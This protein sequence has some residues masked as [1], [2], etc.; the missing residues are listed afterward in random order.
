MDRREFVQRATA[1]TAA[2]GLAPYARPGRKEA[3]S[4]RVVVDGLDTSL[5]NEGFLE[6]LETGGVDC[7][8]KSMGEPAYYGMIYA[9][10]AHHRDV[11]VPAFTVKEIREAKS[12]GKRSIIFGAQHANLLEAMMPKDVSGT[13]G[14]LV[15]GLKLY[16][17]L[18]QR[19]QGICYNVA[20]VFGGGCLDPRVPLTRAGHRLV[21]E[22]HKIRM[23]LDVAGHT[24]EQTSLDAL[25]MSTGVPVICTHTNSAA[26]NPNARATTDRV[27]EAIAWTGG[28]VGITS[29]SDFQMRNPANYQ[30]Q[31]KTSPQATLDVHLKQ[32]DYMKKRIGIDHI[33]LGPDFVWGWGE[34]LNH[35]AENSLTFPPDALSDGPAVTTKDYENISK[36]PNLIAGLR[37][38]GWSEPDLD[39]LLGANWLRVYEKVWG[40]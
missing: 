40:A 9:F 13:Y 11:I 25:E 19:F 2:L 4:S 7:V 16:Y 18:G 23:I 27:L 14:Q 39:K 22:V 12:Q 24:G 17:D 1:T 37:S 36:L 30:S 32:Y 21:E 5:I 31:G 33:A 3:Q 6:L 8:H 10:L 29:I 28:E 26:L 34:A 20:N 35:R 38:R 15:A